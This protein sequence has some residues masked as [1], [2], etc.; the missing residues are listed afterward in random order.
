[1]GIGQTLLS[2]SS[3]F[4][5]SNTAALSV[6][7][8]CE[9]CTS[10]RVCLLELERPLLDSHQIEWDIYRK[11]EHL[12][13]SKTCDLLLIPSC[14]SACFFWSYKFSCHSCTWFIPVPSW[15]KVG[16]RAS[17]NRLDRLVEV[18]GCRDLFRGQTMPIIITNGMTI[19]NWV[20]NQRHILWL[21]NNCSCKGIQCRCR[22]TSCGLLSGWCSGGFHIDISIKEHPGS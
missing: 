18:T 1:M 15:L 7:V 22:V 10:S 5:S 13:L 2:T 9:D 19:S 16:E 3:Q 21:N 17:N 20:S 11:I 4:P 8:G 12:L 6:W 14:H